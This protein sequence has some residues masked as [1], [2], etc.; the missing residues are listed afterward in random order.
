MVGSE[1]MATKKR[2]PGASGPSG[3]HRNPQR[4]LS[5]DERAWEEQD[6]AAA[7]AGIRWAD[8]AREALRREVARLAKKDR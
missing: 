8:L 2:R 5:Q 7:Q 4:L 1:A 3:A 6:A